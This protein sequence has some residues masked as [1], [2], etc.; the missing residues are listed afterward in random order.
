M[1]DAVVEELFPTAAITDQHAFYD[2]VGDD[3]TLDRNRTEML[4]SVGR[5]L[6]L[7]RID[8]LPTSRYVLQPPG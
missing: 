4:A 3:D 1:Y 2:A 5:F 8:V 7:D 6:D